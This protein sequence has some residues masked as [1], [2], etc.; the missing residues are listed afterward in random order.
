MS[1][2]LFKMASKKDTAFKK[3]EVK[4]ILV[5]ALS[6]TVVDFILFNIRG[7]QGTLPEKYF[8]PDINLSK[9]LFALKI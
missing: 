4:V 6:W 2:R 3:H 8:S 5:I 1:M 9:E 7:L